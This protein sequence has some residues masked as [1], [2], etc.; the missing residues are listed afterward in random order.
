[1]SNFFPIKVVRR[2]SETQLRVGDNL[3]QIVFNSGKRIKINLR[4]YIHEEERYN[5]GD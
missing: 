3:N 4:L 1:M 2:G 5:R